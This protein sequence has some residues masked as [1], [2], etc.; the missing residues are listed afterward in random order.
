MCVCVC[1]CAR[2]RSVFKIIK[3]SRMVW[4]MALI[5]RELSSKKMISGLSDL[6][7][8]DYPTKFFSLKH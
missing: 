3:P 4:E 5:K 6:M 7:C 2:S 1:V 8:N